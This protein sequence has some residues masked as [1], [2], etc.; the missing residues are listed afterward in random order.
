M[1]KEFYAELIAKL[2]LA[3]EKLPAQ[4]DRSQWPAMKERFRAL[5][6]TRTRDEWCRILEGSDVCLAPVLSM[7]EAQ[8]HPHNRARGTFVEGAGAPQPGPAPRFS[9]TQAQIE[10]PP[11]HAG[12]H[13]DEA[14][15]AWGFAAD[16]IRR[17]REAKAIA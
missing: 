4:L 8:G 14:L 17:L 11:P 5:F 9:R 1:E 10:R 6:Q 7:R 16:E 2:G 3:E 15:G 12:Q 13:T